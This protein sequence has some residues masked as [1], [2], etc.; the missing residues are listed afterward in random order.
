MDEEF[1]I[2][3]PIPL[4]VVSTYFQVPSACLGS[5]VGLVGVFAAKQRRWPP[6]PRQQPPRP[7][8]CLRPPGARASRASRAATHRAP[9]SPS[10]TELPQAHNK[11]WRQTPAT[12]PPQAQQRAPTRLY[13]CGPSEERKS[14]GRRYG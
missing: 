4:G 12:K 10:T 5:V 8:S 9:I 11:Q 13:C 7:R 2:A 6:W 3:N 1:W 14:S